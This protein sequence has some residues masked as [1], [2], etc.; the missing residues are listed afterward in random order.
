MPE[1]TMVKGKQYSKILKIEF[2]YSSNI[3]KCLL[4][5]VKFLI[6][7]SVN[8]DLYIALQNIS[9]FILYFIFELWVQNTVPWFTSLISMPPNRK[10]KN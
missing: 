1:W 4:Q 7:F 8:K 9:I 10:E 6:G 5:N 3:Q 2:E